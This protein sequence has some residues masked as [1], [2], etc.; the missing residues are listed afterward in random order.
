[1][2]SLCQAKLHLKNIIKEPKTTNV[3]F[4]TSKD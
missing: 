2:S 1:L 4:F 3:S